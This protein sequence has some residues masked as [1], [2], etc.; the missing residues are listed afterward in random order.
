M[1]HFYSEIEKNPNALAKALQTAQIK[2]INSNEY[3]NPYY[4]A[5]FI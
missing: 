3:N 5:P 4:W 2:M 1:K